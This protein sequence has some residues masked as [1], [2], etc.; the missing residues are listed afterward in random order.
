VRA[1]SNAYCPRGHG[2]LQKGLRAKEARG[3]WSDRELIELTKPCTPMA[4]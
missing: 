4:W 2:K 3:A 1:S